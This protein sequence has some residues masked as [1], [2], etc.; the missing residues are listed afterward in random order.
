MHMFNGKILDKNTGL[1][2]TSSANKNQK[3]PLTI[4]HVCPLSHLYHLPYLV[5]ID[6]MY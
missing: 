2:S 1:L 4:L 3:K 6:V 5:L